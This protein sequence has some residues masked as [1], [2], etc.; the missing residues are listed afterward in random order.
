MTTVTGGFS[1]P[2]EFKVDEFLV[3]C[4]K[5][6]VSSKTARH[7]LDIIKNQAD[8][9]SRRSESVAFG[10]RKVS[11][12]RLWWKEEATACTTTILREGRKQG[13]SVTKHVS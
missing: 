5:G 12:E 13:R 4:E 7:R 6:S 11:N 3:A 1:F 8:L 10:V 2:L 9:H